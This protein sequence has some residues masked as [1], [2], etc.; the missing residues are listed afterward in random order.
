MYNQAFE[1]KSS[2]SLFCDH[3][4]IPLLKRNTLKHLFNY[5]SSNNNHNSFTHHLRYVGEYLKSQEMYHSLQELQLFM[6]DFLN[7][8][9]T[10]I[11]LFTFDRKNYID[12]YEKRL[13][14]LQDALN[15][16]QKAKVDTQ[17]SLMKI[18]RYEKF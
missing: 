1:H 5:I 4:Y 18:Q 15:C 8:V 10:S 2:L 13:K 3:I 6:N 16:C 12:L 17:Q 14:Y 7:A 9:H 11:Q